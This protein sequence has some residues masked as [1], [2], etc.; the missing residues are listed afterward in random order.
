LQVVITALPQV[1]VHR[2]M[3]LVT[4]LLRY[5]TGHVAH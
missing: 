4:T 2:R 3:A 5:T 1:P